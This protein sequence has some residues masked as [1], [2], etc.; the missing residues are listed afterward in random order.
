MGFAF[1]L[2]FSIC[3]ME[4]QC[5]SHILPELWHLLAAE[6]GCF[7]SPLDN[8]EM[9]GDWGQP[10]FQ[11]CTDS[12]TA[13]EGFTVTYVLKWTWQLHMWKGKLLASHLLATWFF[14]S[15]AA[16]KSGF[17][18]DCCLMYYL[19]DLNQLS[20][21]VK[22]SSECVCLFKYTKLCVRN[23]SKLWT[24]P[25]KMLGNVYKWEL[26]RLQTLC[27]LCPWRAKETQSDIFPHAR[28]G[29]LTCVSELRGQ[30]TPWSL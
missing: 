19:V 12:E 26:E 27:S 10:C 28:Y 2:S 25:R 22:H 16:H 21:S 9:F 7:F 13:P 14:N 8:L 6:I 5:W 4:R 24:L 18:S 20:S 11:F 17:N 30:V 23:V 15:R 3:K 29:L 1:S